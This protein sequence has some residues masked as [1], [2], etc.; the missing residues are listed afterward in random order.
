MYT[1]F[2]TLKDMDITMSKVDK[3]III[4]TVLCRHYYYVCVKHAYRVVSERGLFT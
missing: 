2:Y 1:I 4:T 3:T